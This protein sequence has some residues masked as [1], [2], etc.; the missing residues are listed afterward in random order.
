MSIVIKTVGKHR[1]AYHSYRDGGRVVHR[2]L[3]NAADDR[4]KESIK[5][6][7]KPARVDPRFHYLFWDTNP[8]GINLRGNA[9]YI[10]ERVLEIGDLSAFRW[11]QRIYPTGLILETCNTSR[12]VSEKSRVFWNIWLGESPR[13]C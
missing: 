11:I 4:V 6:M 13:A 3:G 8:A 9:R 2:Y 1:Y 5:K 12:K 7:K 10:I